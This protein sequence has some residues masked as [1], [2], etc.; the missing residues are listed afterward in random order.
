MD[1]TK[2]MY[3]KTVLVDE[4]WHRDRKGKKERKR[5]CKPEV[6]CLPFMA[7]N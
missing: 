2:A 1:F 7:R 4:A 5:D 3:Y 6:I